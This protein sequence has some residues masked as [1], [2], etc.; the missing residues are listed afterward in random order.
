[1]D[2]Q[3]QQANEISEEELKRITESIEITDVEIA[4]NKLNCSVLNKGPLTVHLVDL[5]AIQ[6]NLGTAMWEKTY[7]I[8]YTL[9][10]GMTARN[11]GTSLPLLVYSNN[12]YAVRVVTERGSSAIAVFVPPTSQNKKMVGP[13][14]FS[15]DYL[16]FNYTTTSDG[17]YY[18]THPRPAWEMVGGKTG[19]LLWVKLTN[20]GVQPISINV[21][22]Y[23]MIYQPYS[24]TGEEENYFYI[25]DN[26]STSQTVTPFTT[27]VIPPNMTN[28][29]TGTSQILKFGAITK[30]GTTLKTFPRVMEDTD[31][32]RKYLFNGF[33]GLFYRWTGI[34]QNYGLQVPLWCQRVYPFAFSATP[35]WVNP[36]QRPTSGTLSIYHVYTLQSFVYASQSYTVQASVSRISGPG[37]ITYQAGPWSH[38]LNNGNLIT[39]PQRSI[40]ITSST[41]PGTYIFQVSF[42]YSHTNPSYSETFTKQLILVVT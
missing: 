30:G 10:P 28:P 41:M 40:S 18:Y 14:I 29:I 12:T 39:S 26:R 19:I 37:T 1:M 3:Q 11:I 15:F 5:Y 21:S 6:Y 13:L 9:N 25:V 17:S 23:V 38:T 16:S 35:Q 2:A 31:S 34:P 33:V 4:S 8:N 27:Q 20:K 22:S 24:D 32:D 42:T 36:V 7:S